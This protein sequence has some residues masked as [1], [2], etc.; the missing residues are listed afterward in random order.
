MR[1]LQRR[2]TVDS[3]PATLRR[4]RWV[5]RFEALFRRNAT[6]CR[7]DIPG[8]TAKLSHDQ[9]AVMDSHC[10][11]KG[12]RYAR[13]MNEP[14]CMY[15]FANHYLSDTATRKQPVD[16]LTIWAE[17]PLLL[18]PPKEGYEEYSV[19]RP[20]SSA[21]DWAGDL[22]ELRLGFF[23]C[24]LCKA[25]DNSQTSTLLATNHV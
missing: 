20:L 1:S 4:Y 3:W 17:L 19:L 14:S 9:I 24:Y 10:S 16:T 12:T 15:Q 8:P 11:S 18:L 23:L 6:V 25:M 5:P 21:V 7:S 22:L 13:Y 2:T